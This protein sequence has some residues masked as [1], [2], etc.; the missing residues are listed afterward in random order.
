MS[1]LYLAADPFGGSYRV[2]GGALTSRSRRTSPGGGY[3]FPQPDPF[4]P[5]DWIFFHA[6]A[7]PGDYDY[8]CSVPG[9]ATMMRGV[10][11]VVA[12]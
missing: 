1:P 2:G 3:P 9:H 6:P 10:L 11:R 4:F 12:K 5:A 7:T 8:V